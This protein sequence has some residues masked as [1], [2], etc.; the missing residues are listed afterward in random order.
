[1]LIRGVLDSEIGIA[2]RGLRK[3]GLMITSLRLH[4]MAEWKSVCDW[5]RVSTIVDLISGNR[6][7]MSSARSGGDVPART[8][9]DD[10]R[11]A[12]GWK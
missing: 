7:V 2:A 12:A 10:C 3:L 5:S 6:C 1:M 9:S 11:N 8:I 4:R